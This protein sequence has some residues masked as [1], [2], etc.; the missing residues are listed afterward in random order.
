MEAK[1]RRI[2]QDRRNALDQL[3]AEVV[4][5]RRTGAISRQESR[6]SGTRVGE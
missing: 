6:S 4:E 5:L 1:N 2:L 3:M